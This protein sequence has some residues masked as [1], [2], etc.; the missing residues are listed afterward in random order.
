MGGLVFKRKMVNADKLQGLGL[1]GF[2]GF[3]YAYFPYMVMHFGKTL[4]YLGMSSASLAGMVKLS[5]SNVVNTISFVDGQV[6]INVSTGP[7]TSQD[8]IAPL[9]HI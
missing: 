4:T 8:I 7:F 6:K 5:D 9:N 3:T 2:A 1:F